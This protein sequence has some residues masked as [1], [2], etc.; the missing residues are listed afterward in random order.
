MPSSPPPPH[1]EVR[2]TDYARR[3]ARRWYVIVASVIIAVGLV[4]VHAV[5]GST[6]QSTA[7]ANV[8]L[9]QPLGQSGSS[10]ITQT[11]Q[12]NASIAVTFVKSTPTLNDAGAKAGLTAARLG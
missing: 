1:R 8:Y 3:A 12:A 2:L 10:V 7:T 11:P 4:F 5:S 6:N 9:G